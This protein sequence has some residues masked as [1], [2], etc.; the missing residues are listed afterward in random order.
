M[1]GMLGVFG[2]L[3]MLAA[4]TTETA[5]ADQCAWIP[6]ATAKK[7]LTF[8]QPGQE[9][10]ALCE[11]CGET[12]T[13]PGPKLR[14]IGK[15]VI[16]ATGDPKYRE[17]AI[18][19]EAVDLAYTYVHAQGDKTGFTNLALLADCPASGVTR[20]L[21]WPP[22]NA[23][24][25]KLAGWFGTYDHPLTRLKITQYYDDPNGLAI[26]IDYPT[27]H[28]SQAATFVLTSYADVDADPPAFATPFGKCRVSLARDATGVVLRPDAACGGLLD[29]IAGSYRKIGD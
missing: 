2:G 11:P 6:E 10:L 20:R 3:G 21:P 29:A 24:A 22:N 25:E 9:W 8:L 19:G 28:P 26:Q 14:R 23:H 17:I 4:T 15:A 13:N 27:E 12:V 1:V 7:A 16:Q 18:D 5:R